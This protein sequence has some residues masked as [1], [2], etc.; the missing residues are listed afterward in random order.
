HLVRRGVETSLLCRREEQAAFMRRERRNPNYLTFLEL[1][2][3][4]RYGTFAEADYAEVDLVVMAVPSK[5]YREAV[6]LLAPRLPLQPA[7]LSLTKG[8]DPSTLQR[9]S[10]VLEEELGGLSP[11]L[12]VL[13]G[14]NHAEEVARDQPTATVIAS[15][16]VSYAR[17]LQVLLTDQNLRAY[18]NTDLVGVELAA[19]T[20]NVIA[21]ATGMSDGLG[22]GD[23]ARAALITR[24]LAE[25][26][27]LG[28]ALGA[29]PQTFAG[30]AGLGDLVGTCT[31]QH[32][33]NRRAG[34]LIAR[35]H[36]ATQV[37]AELGMV[38]EGLT[39]ARAVLALARQHQVE[40]PITEN[41]VA[42]VFGGKDVRASV[43]D[44]MAR[45]PRA[46]VM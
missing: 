14:P 5:A 19:A 10:E 37:E 34:E 2:S 6:R 15:R 35:G 7:I 40:M 44:L 3:E 32:S 25:M 38:A 9:L 30:L 16:D 43:R 28:L 4:L 26:T 27:R 8:L 22:Y 41:V 23:N 42:V 21:L 29:L 20:K 11:R 13:S 31:S 39:A 1:P 12:A 36:L 46:E 24:G 18:V 33:R 17:T 45:Q